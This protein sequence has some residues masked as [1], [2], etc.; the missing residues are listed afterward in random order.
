M[1]DRVLISKDQEQNVSTQQLLFNM[2]MH[3]CAFFRLHLE[4]LPYLK[5]RVYNPGELARELA[6]FESGTSFKYPHPPIPSVLCP[7]P[8]PHKLGIWQWDSAGRGRADLVN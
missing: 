5:P 1:F 6:R 8:C 2:C 4:D 3:F 7:K